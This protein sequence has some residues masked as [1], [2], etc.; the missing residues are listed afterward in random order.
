MLSCVFCECV[1]FGFWNKLNSARAT[2]IYRI[3]SMRS[4]FFSSFLFFIGNILSEIEARVW[5]Q[6]ERDTHEEM[7]GVWNR[8]IV[9][10]HDS[11]PN[12]YVMTRVYLLLILTS[13]RIYWNIW[14]APVEINLLWIICCSFFP[15]V[16]CEIESCFPLTEKSRFSFST[17]TSNASLLASVAIRKTRFDIIWVAS[18]RWLV[19]SHLRAYFQPKEQENDRQQRKKKHEI[20]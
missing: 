12:F 15:S 11:N 17:S 13:L 8:F 10:S 20:D 16:V 14:F 4:S 2:H 6:A 5:L 9:E 3:V 1:F 18:W 7:F 19:R